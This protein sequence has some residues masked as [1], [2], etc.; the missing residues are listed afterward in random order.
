[1]LFGELLPG[2]AIARARQMSDT[3]DAVLAV[4][5]TLSVYP[6]VDFVLDPVFR[7]APLVIANLGPTDYDRLATVRVDGPAATTIPSI[8]QGLLASS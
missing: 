5:S 2:A 6:A 3:A 1:V 4:G 7:G 8:V